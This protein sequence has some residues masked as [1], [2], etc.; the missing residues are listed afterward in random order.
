M[1]YVF[2]VRNLNK[3]GAQYR[4]GQSMVC[5]QHSPSDSAVGEGSVCHLLLSYVPH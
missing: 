2:S 1:L 4:L 5:S 3:V